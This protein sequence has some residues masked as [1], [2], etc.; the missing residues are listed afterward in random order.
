MDM[1]DAKDR[2]VNNGKVEAQ[3]VVYLKDWETKAKTRH[4]LRGALSWQADLDFWR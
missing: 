4:D 1:I 2:V 3:F